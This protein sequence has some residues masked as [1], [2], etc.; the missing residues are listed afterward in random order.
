MGHGPPNPVPRAVALAIEVEPDLASQAQS[1]RL[2][3]GI[4]TPDHIEIEG[5]V[6][7]QTVGREGPPFLGELGLAGVHR[8][9]VQDLD[10]ANRGIGLVGPDLLPGPGRRE[11]RE[12]EG[13]PVT[14]VTGLNIQDPMTGPRLQEQAAIGLQARGQGAL[15]RHG[16]GALRQGR[17]QDDLAGTAGDVEHQAA[18]Q[19]HRHPLLQTPEDLEPQAILRRGDEGVRQ[20]RNREPDLT[21]IVQC[22]KG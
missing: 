15:E 6:L 18:A 17:R 11:R 14:L 7:A 2:G 22:W 16:D 13:A 5:Q 4:A 3:D 1:I 9:G 8:G 19:P 10:E 20:C 12:G 21:L